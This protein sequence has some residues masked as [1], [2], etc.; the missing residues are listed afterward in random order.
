MEKRTLFLIFLLSILLVTLSVAA[1][2]GQTCRETP[3][4]KKRSCSEATPTELEVLKYI[5]KT[6]LKFG[7]T[8]AIEEITVSIK[9]SDRDIIRTLD[10]LER[11]DFLLRKKGTQEIISIYPFSLAPTE[12]QIFLEDGKKLFA[13]CAVDALGMPLMFN[14]DIKIVSQC[15]ECKQ[16]I[17]IKIKNGEIVSMSH[18]NIMIWSPKRQEARPAET[19]CPRVNFF[20]S[21]EH[22]EE[23]EAKNT[24]L[25]R[26]G[27]S[28]RLQQAFPRIKKCWKSYGETLRIR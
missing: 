16:E 25:A 27:H 15:E 7:R 23:W 12:H 9:K 11:K 17:T 13:M 24:E 2:E 28:V 8:P 21:K 14:N 10:E 19:C 6:I 1:K 3:I 26:I 20:C 4:E 18:P 22:V 5:F